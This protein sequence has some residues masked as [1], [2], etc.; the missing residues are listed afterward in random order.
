MERKE[1]F[2][3]LFVDKDGH[4]LGHANTTRLDGLVW[5]KRL[6]AKLNR[7]YKNRYIDLDP[8]NASRNIN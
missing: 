5:Y 1:R 4:L 2:G 6:W 8:F 7:G 3:I